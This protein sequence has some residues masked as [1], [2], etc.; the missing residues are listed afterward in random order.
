ME[1]PR[2]VIRNWRDQDPANSHGAVGWKVM[3]QLGTN[4]G[5]IV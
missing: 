4:P 2:P 1:T 3:M 5:R